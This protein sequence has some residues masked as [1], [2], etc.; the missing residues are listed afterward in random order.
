[1][2]SPETAPA[3]FPRAAQARLIEAKA[4]TSFWLDFIVIIAA[5]GDV[6]CFVGAMLIAFYARRPSF[7]SAEQYERTYPLASYS[8]HFVFGILLF[9]AIAGRAGMYSSHNFIKLRQIFI[10]AMNTA[11]VWALCYVCLSLLFSFRPSISRLFVIFSSIIGFAFVIYWRFLFRFILNRNGI[12][13]R[14]RQRLVVVGWNLEVDNL[15]R[16]ILNDAFHPYEI[17]GC[18]PSVHNQYQVPPPEAVRRLGAYEDLAGIHKSEAIDIIL[19]GDLDQNTRET[20]ALCDFCQRELIQFKVLP[21]YFQILISGLHL[22]TISG[23][24]VLGI[25]KLPL[26]SLVSR[27]IKRT[28]DIIGA[29]VGLVISVPLVL[30]FGLWVF[31]E[32]PGPIIYRQERMGRRGD[33]FTIYKIRSMHLD[34]E[35]GG[36]QWARPND[37]RRLRIG[38]FMRRWNIDEVPQFWNV[39][40]GSMSLVGPRPERSELIIDFKDQIRHYNARHNVKPGMTGWAQIH[41]LRGDTDLNERLRYD[42]YYLENWTPVL[43]I[44]IMFMTFIVNRNAY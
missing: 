29:L 9:L 20:I 2:K 38:G 42:L 37:S 31:W 35:K 8:G 4:S 19:L 12:L 23:V 34:A 11:I 27:L 44:Y 5:V 43:D 39:L 21:T 15:A 14:L 6:I 28:M 33:K 13:K 26:D 18:L 1:M 22:E 7:I 17:V 10:A 36:V 40:L 30:V 16:A 3:E 32:S 25:A 24:P 41:G